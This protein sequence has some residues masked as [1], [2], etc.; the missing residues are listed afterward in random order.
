LYSPI[1]TIPP[2]TY[3][4]A[5]QLREELEKASYAY[6]VLDAPM[7]PDSVYD[8]LYRELQELEEQYPQLIRPDSPT[9]RVGD[10]I[11]DRF[12]SVPHHIP[13]YSLENAFTL[14]ELQKWSERWQRHLGASPEVEY[15]CELKIDGNALALTYENGYLVRGATRGDGTTGEEIT[16]NVRTIR[17]IP[18]KLTLDNPPARVEVRGEAF[19]PLDTFAQIN[20]EREEQGESLFANPRNAASG[21]LRQLDPKI[22]DKRRLQFFA[23]TLHLEG[24]SDR[25]QWQALETLQKMGFL[26]NPERKLARSPEE[27]QQYYQYWHTARHDLPYMTDGV[28]VKINDFS[29]QETLGFTQKFPRWAVAL[30]YPAEEVPTIVKDIIVNVGRTGAVTPMAVMEPVQVAGTTV[31]RAT[32]HNRDRVAELDIRVGDTVIIRKAGEIIPEVVKVLRELRPANTQAYEMPMRCPECDSPLVRPL[33]E[34][35]TRCVNS[36]CP[37]ILRGSLV[38]WASRDALD[39][40]GLGEKVVILLIEQ[41]LISSIAD[42]YGLEIEAIAQLER[43]GRKSAA[44]L[45]TAIEESKNQPWS[46][47][48]Y[49]LGIRYVGAVNAKILTESFPNVEI[50][51]NASVTALASVYGI[52]EQIAESVHDWFRVEANRQLVEELKKA[53]LSMEAIAKPKITTTAITGKTFVITGTLPTLKRDEAKELI[54]KAGGKVTGSVS[55]KTDYLVV[56]EDAGS[57]LD[58]AIELGINQLSEAQLLALLGS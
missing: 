16:P 2:S 50:L 26:V 14:E 15:V 1:V 29:L 8:Q 33:E 3:Q 40:R 22:V 25:S 13:L 27:V 10:K 43:M 56:G 32:L 28:V 9:R 19:L 18:L 54:E 21:T 51:G 49:G 52:G 17:S 12:V 55:K 34:A 36:S 58:K 39:I 5:E 23:Y 4:R 6:Y 44:N 31:Q 42:L 35:V 57:K 7:L 24:S 11:S 45:I 37:A 46:R 48:L 30:K 53:G 38:H 20:A 47:V 41:G